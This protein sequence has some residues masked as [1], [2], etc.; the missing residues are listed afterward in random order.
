MFH[1][2]LDFFVALVKSIL[3]NL[4]TITYKRAF[5]GPMNWIAMH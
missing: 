5:L 2:N 3:K 4:D 1:K